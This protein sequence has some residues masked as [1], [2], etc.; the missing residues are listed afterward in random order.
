MSLDF[1]FQQHKK[2]C[3][4]IV[5]ILLKDSYSLLAAKWKLA[6]V[7]SRGPEQYDMISVFDGKSSYFF[8][9]LSYFQDELFCYLHILTFIILELL[10]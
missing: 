7:Y 5:E 9:Y 2:R 4:E 1:L 10:N 3:F 8:V 6:L